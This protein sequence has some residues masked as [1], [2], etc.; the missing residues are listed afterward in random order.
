MRK[1]RLGILVGMKGRGSN[2]RAIA[3]ACRDGKINAEVAVVITQAEG[4]PAVETAQALGLP[5]AII[6]HKLENYGV[7]LKDALTSAGVDIVCLAGFMRLLPN[8]VLEAYEN[9]VLNI[10]PALLPK[11]GGKGMWGMHVH[12]AVV[13]ARESISGC[14]VHYVT[15]HYDE[16]QVILQLQTEL[17]TTDTPEDVAA[18]VLKLEHQAYPMAIQKVWERIHE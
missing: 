8:E 16:G 17:E 4:T 14:S 3:E 12:E 18:K 13:A 9:R 11:F 2:M 10:H 6:S 7:Q 1:A 15:E 5:I